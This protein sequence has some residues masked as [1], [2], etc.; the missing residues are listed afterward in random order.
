MRETLVVEGSSG[1]RKEK[2][3]AVLLQDDWSLNL[4]VIV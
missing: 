4:A 2:C 3:S 1:A